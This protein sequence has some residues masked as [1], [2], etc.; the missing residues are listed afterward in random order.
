MEVTRQTRPRTGSQPSSRLFTATVVA[1]WDKPGR[2]SPVSVKRQLIPWEGRAGLEGRG[3]VFRSVGTG[4]LRAG[5]N[6]S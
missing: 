3:A 5:A 6:G 4:S 2:K 1:Y